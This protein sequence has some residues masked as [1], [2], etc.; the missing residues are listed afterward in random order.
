MGGCEKRIEVIVCENA[1]K[2]VR[3][4]HFVNDSVLIK[5]SHKTNV[6]TLI[7]ISSP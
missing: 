4:V 2:R 5:F 1:K 6:F 7:I 3:M